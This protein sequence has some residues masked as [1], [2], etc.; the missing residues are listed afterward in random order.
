MI[1]FFIEKFKNLFQREEP[2]TLIFEVTDGCNLSCRYC[3]RPEGQ[4]RKMNHLSVDNLQKIRK[5]LL[6]S[7]K[8]FSLGISGGEPLL[9]PDIEALLPLILEIDANANLLT[10]LSLLDRSKAQ[11]LRKTGLKE[12]QITLFSPLPEQHNYLRNTD[13]FAR[14]LEGIAILKETGFR[15]ET[16]LLVT[17]KNYQM[18][19]P[20]MEMIKSLG[21]AGFMINRY[22]AGFPAGNAD[23]ESLFIRNKSFLNWIDELENFA[24][25]NNFQIPFAIPIPPCTLPE[26]KVFPHLA[27]SFCPLGREAEYLTLSPNGDLRPCNHLPIILGNLCD[28][29]IEEIIAGEEYQKLLRQINSP[30]PFCRNCAAWKSCRGGCRGAAFSWNGSID[31]HDPWLDRVFACRL[32]GSERMRPEYDEKEQWNDSLSLKK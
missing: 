25:A 14:T 12:I 22:N 8:R 5:N 15:I 29:T 1:K 16:I 2:R 19:I 21:I 31:Q 20:A 24:A 27:F 3:Y 11:S 13:D 28:Q 10:N 6:K 4:N 18:T 30:P 17:E 26:N 7:N 32:K 23:A 9:H